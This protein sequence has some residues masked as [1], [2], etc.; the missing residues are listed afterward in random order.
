MTA[1]KNRRLVLLLL[2]ALAVGLVSYA[3]AGDKGSWTGW[4]TD[5]HCGAKGAKADHKGC[6]EQ[7]ISKGGKLV[8]YNTA[9]QK[10][11][12]LDNQT[13]AKEHLGHE[14]KVTGEADGAAIKVASIAMA[15]GSK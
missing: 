4:I 5:E 12:S 11:Y 3:D 14:V 6:A 15:E 1:M 8:F 2:L 9:D 13:L 10:I 7:C